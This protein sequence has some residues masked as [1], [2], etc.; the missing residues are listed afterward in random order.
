MWLLGNHIT[1]TTCFKQMHLV[2]GM[3]HT[4]IDINHQKLEI[5]TKHMASN[6][7]LALEE[8]GSVHSLT[9]LLIV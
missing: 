3:F 7:S 1:A 2:Y 4:G 9:L 5:I 8:L 6:Q